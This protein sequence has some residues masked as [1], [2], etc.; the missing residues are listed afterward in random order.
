MGTVEG[1]LRELYGSVQALQVP[2]EQPQPS[3]SCLPFLPPLTHRRRTRRGGRL[4]STSRTPLPPSNARRRHVV[5]SSLPCAAASRCCPLPTGYA[6]VRNATR[7]LRPRGATRRGRGTLRARRQRR[8]RRLARRLQ[9]HSG[10]Q[11][12][13][14]R[15][16]PRQASVDGLTAGVGAAWGAACGCRRAAAAGPLAILPSYSPNVVIYLLLVPVP[17]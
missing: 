13:V 5:T 8:R 17:N 7:S 1:L 3:Y 4:S 11:R 9:P 16:W 12:S 6:H 15:S 2:L 14:A 10:T